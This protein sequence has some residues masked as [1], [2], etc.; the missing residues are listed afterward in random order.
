MAVFG[1]HKPW[2][3]HPTT[4]TTPQPTFWAFLGLLNFFS[5]ACFGMFRH[6]SVFFLFV[7]PKVDSP[8]MCRFFF[9][10]STGSPQRTGFSPTSCWFSPTSCWFSP[11]SCWFSTSRSHLMV[12]KAF[13]IRP[14]VPPSN[15]Q[16]LAATIRLMRMVEPRGNRGR[17]RWWRSPRSCFSSRC[18][19][20]MIH[21]RHRP[22]TR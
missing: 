15:L 12:Q 6:I 1:R 5:L 19:W 3:C 10:N 18:A 21:P 16:A 20:P 11:T 9:E 13:P 7:H 8:Q 2:K 4:P 22:K 17:R 14:V